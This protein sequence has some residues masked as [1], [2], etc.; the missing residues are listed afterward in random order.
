MVLAPRHYN[1]AAMIVRV[2]V[3]L[4]TWELTLPDCPAGEEDAVKLKEW[5]WKH[6]KD[7]LLSQLNFSTEPSTSISV[8]PAEDD[9]DEDDEELEVEEVDLEDEEE[10]EQSPRPARNGISQRRSGEEGKRKRRRH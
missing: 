2:E 5:V 6:G 7:Q 9:D 1:F 10:E 8:N 4:P 3:K